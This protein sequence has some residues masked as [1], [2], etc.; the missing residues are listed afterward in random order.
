[1]VE[2]TLRKGYGGLLQ[3]ATRGCCVPVLSRLPRLAGCN[4]ICFSIRSTDLFGSMLAG[5]ITA[6]LARLAVADR[7]EASLARTVLDELVQNA[8][9]HGN[10]G[11]PT[12]VLE[13]MDDIDRFNSDIASRLADPAY[14][15]KHVGIGFWLTSAGWT[16]EIVDDG[17]G[18]AFTG[19]GS[20]EKLSGNSGYSGRGSQIVRS[21]S[22]AVHIDRG[23]RRT[24]VRF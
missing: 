19:A 7:E 21:L 12:R 8:I 11:L 13:S 2:E 20:P 17:D 16:A 5:A 15:M 1:M 3:V 24:L 9:V 22:K 4:L 6:G 18:Y 14:G 23:G 10:L